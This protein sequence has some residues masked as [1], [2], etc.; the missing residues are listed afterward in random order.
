MAENEVRQDQEV[1]NIEN[2]VMGPLVQVV[3]DADEE[4]ITFPFSDLGVEAGD[5]GMIADDDLIQLAEDW[6]RLERGVDIEP[7]ALRGYKVTRPATGNVV[8][9]RPAVFGVNTQR[10]YCPKCKNHTMHQ[11]HMGYWECTVCGQWNGRAS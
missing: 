8:L 10:R 5:P 7:N 9:S 2:A 3:L 1:A 11:E 4:P 6:L